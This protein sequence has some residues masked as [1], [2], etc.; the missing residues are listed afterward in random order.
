MNTT[1][2]DRLKILRSG[3]TQ[4]WLAE[5]LTIPPTTLSNYENNKSELNY[6]M[7]EAITSIFHVNADWLLFGTGPM[8][9]ET[10]PAGDCSD[11]A[12]E[13]VALK[14]ENA[15]L[16]ETLAAK[17]EALSAYKELLRVTRANLD[18]QLDKSKAETIDA[19]VSVL[20]ALSPR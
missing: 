13:I 4:A 19:P 14:A 18:E 5:K 9:G 20:S 16:K 17:T 2:G 3:H 8:R 6:G 15:L 10:A 11:M 7:I 12:A 1:V